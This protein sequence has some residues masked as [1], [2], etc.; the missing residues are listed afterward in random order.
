MARLSILAAAAIATAL[1]V[2]AAPAQAAM[3]VCQTTKT[4]YR[5]T[6]EGAMTTSTTFVELPKSRAV[7]RQGGK[8]AGCVIVRLS[9]VPRD[10]YIMTVRAVMDEAKVARPDYVEL[11]YESPGYLSPRGFEF[12]FPKVSPGRHV[13]RIEWHTNTSPSDESRMYRRTVTVEHR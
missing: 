12:V 10:D 7:F 2:S 6:T 1:A 4:H 8:K 3:G 13:V 11:E 9:A 5:T